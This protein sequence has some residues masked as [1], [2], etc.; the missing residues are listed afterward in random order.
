MRILSVSQVYHPFGEM[1]GPAFKVK[2]IAEHMVRCGHNVTVLATTFDAHRASG[3]Q[4]VVGVEVCYLKPDIRYRTT[5]W[6]SGVQKFCDSRL[7]E[8][9]VV[10]IYGLYDLMGPAVARAC[11][12]QGI[13]YIVEPLGMTRAIDRSFF[14]KAMWHK[15]IG[16]DYMH[17]AASVV[18]TSEQEYDEL[19]AEGFPE[20]K[21]FL[22]YNGLDTAEFRSLPPRD[23]FRLRHNIAGDEPLVLF[24]SRLIERKGAD[25]LIA[26]F[27]DACPTRGRLVIAGPEGVPGYVAGL[28]DVA[29]RCGVA[30][31]VLFTGPLFGEEKKEAL[32][33]ADVFALPSRYENFANV[34][35]ESMACGTPVIVTR[36]CG[37]STHVEGKAGLV[38]PREIPALADA[39]KK[40]LRNPELRDAF[41]AGCAEVAARLSWECV[42]DPMEQLYAALSDGRG[43]SRAS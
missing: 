17:A 15:W 16:R 40:L 22:R 13:P 5:T 31:R 27:A 36:N 4:R 19:R 28:Q 1:G 32:V 7:R 30:E 2:A 24:L 3:S 8:F 42:L 6:N 35:A 39:L 41:R 18:A 37:I 33:A 38:I 20:G 26:A 29:A 10:H 21:L 34:A 9:G 23:A 12:R 43:G 11:R 25:L 14:L